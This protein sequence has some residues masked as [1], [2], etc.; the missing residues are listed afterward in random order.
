MARKQTPSPDVEATDVESDDTLDQSPVA[1][2]SRA[3]GD[4]PTLSPPSLASLLRS[5]QFDIDDDATDDDVIARMEELETAAEER[6]RLRQENEQYR[7]MIAQ[8]RQQPAPEPKAE[9]PKPPAPKTVDVP[10]WDESW[11]GWLTTDDRGAIVVRQEY[12]GA[13]DPTLPEK[14]MKYK[15]WEREQ[16]R[17]IITQGSQFD[18]SRLDER[19]KAEREAIRKELLEEFE[20]KQQHA[21]TTSLLDQYEEQHKSWL[22]QSP[23]VLSPL[24]TALNNSLSEYLGY[25]IPT[26]KALKLAQADVAEHTGQRPWVSE[27]KDEAPAKTPAQKRVALRRMKTNGS[28]RLPQ[29][30]VRRARAADEIL[31]TPSVRQLS[32]SWASQ[33]KAAAGI[34]ES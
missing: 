13:V 34:D 2:L 33:L 32:E 15:K 4:D 16:F 24:G 18:E 14:Y 21:K 7:Q 3:G 6:E 26:D 29:A 20:K 1:D 23:G 30:P 5:R 28:G 22:Y 31:E 10:D 8:Q 25:G 27:E 17:K 9:E 19:L 12:R 11:E